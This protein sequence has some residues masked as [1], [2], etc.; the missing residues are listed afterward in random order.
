MKDTIELYN[1]IKNLTPLPNISLMFE[2]IKDMK[3]KIKLI[4]VLKEHFSKSLNTASTEVKE[5]VQSI[6][7]IHNNLEETGEVIKLLENLSPDNLEK[8]ISHFSEKKEEAI[9]YKAEPKPINKPRLEKDELIKY[10][11][12]ELILDNKPNIKYDDLITK[13]PQVSIKELE[14]EGLIIIGRFNSIKLTKPKQLELTKVVN[15]QLKNNWKVTDDEIL[16]Y[17][18]K[19]NKFIRHTNLYDN[20]KIKKEKDKKIFKYQIRKLVEGDKVISKRAVIGS[21]KLRNEAKND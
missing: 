8:I 3:E 9:E 2:Q 13:F 4:Y 5:F 16:N 6:T 17:L 20:F 21:I 1:K 15:E 19:L 11:V 7:E 18:N 10:F 14:E 12:D